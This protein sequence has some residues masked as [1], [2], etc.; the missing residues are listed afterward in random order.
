[1]VKVIIKNTA[2]NRECVV[3]T[4]KTP[5]QILEDVGID[6]CGAI[7]SLNGSPLSP[8]AFGKTLE[9]SGIKDGET[10]Y[11]TS[12]VKADGARI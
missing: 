5:A 3:E 6:T 2:G 7:V 4:T 9:A 1:M 10:A 8:T 11:L 12:I